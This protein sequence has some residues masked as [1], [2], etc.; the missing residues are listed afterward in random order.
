[1]DETMVQRVDTLIRE[2]QQRFA[3]VPTTT[4]SG[5]MLQLSGYLGGIDQA[6]RALAEEVD[7]LRARLS[8]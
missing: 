5:A 2:A 7:A 6:V 3:N 8:D 1:M 4:D